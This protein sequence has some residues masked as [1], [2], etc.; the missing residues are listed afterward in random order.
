[1]PSRQSK[2]ALTNI[3]TVP[4]VLPI[5][6][7]NHIDLRVCKSINQSEPEGQ[8]LILASDESEIQ[9]QGNQGFFFLAASR[10]VLAASRL[11]HWK[12]KENLW[13]Q[14][15]WFSESILSVA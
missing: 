14:G 5:K 4:S 9:V 11:S 10:L 3:P 13:D 8:I 7:T 12:K 15:N 2:S 1:M 6:R